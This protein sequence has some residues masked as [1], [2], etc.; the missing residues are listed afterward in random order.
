MRLKESNLLSP[1]V[2]SFLCKVFEFVIDAAPKAVLHSLLLLKYQI[3]LH[4]AL[5]VFSL[6]L[7]LE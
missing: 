2:E 1:C 7:L 5:S 4:H 3:Y 6:Q